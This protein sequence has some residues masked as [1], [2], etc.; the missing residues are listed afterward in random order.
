[1]GNRALGALIDDSNESAVITEVGVWLDQV[2]IGM[3]LC[4]FAALPRKQGSV[5]FEVLN[6]SD[7]IAIL[8]G[9]D[10]C[11]QRM[12]REDAKQLE[13][14]LV[15][16]PNA[17][18]EF[19]DYNQFLGAVDALLHTAGFSGEFQVASFHP[20]Y[21][22][23]ETE[24]C[25]PTNLT[26]CAPYPIFHILREDSLEQALARYPE[27]E[28]IPIRNVRLMQSLRAEDIGKIFPYWRFK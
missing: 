26:N 13:T 1:M 12:A 17:F 3:A 4:P 2:V 21:Q 18:V 23:A 22:F 5:A 15:I 10:N 9:I 25:D 19:S 8:K 14:M 28:G 7:E 6:A 16:M 20:D 11:L 27:P 24:A